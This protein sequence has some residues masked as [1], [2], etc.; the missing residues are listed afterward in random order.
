MGHAKKDLM[1]HCR[2]ELMHGVWKFL[3][4]EDFIHAYKYGMVVKC[5]DGIKRRLY[6]RFF[7]YSA[8][9]PEK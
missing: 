1:T 4:D 9:Y 6:P 3:L 8:D 2:R 7:T 5:A